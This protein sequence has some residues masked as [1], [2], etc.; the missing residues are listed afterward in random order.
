[1]R[2]ERTP[3]FLGLSAAIALA[4]LGQD[5]PAAALETVATCGQVVA[6]A[7]ILG[8][9]LDC[10]SETG[11][12]VVLQRGA[13]LTLA[14]FTI[15]GNEGGVLCTGPSCKIF[16]PGTIRRTVADPNTESYGIWGQQ[17][18]RV[19]D[20]VIL[21]NWRRGFL[22]LGSGKLIDV[23]ISG[24]VIGAN[25]A[26]LRVLGS[27]FSG[28]EFAVYGAEGTKDSGLHYTF[29]SCRVR[30][31]TFTGND[32]DISCYRAPKVT[33]TTCTTSWHTTIP[34]TPFSGGDEWGVCG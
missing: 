31:S 5:V 20:G 19:Q 12:A 11:P 13:R 2:T 21:E 18:T 33:D 27:S 10:S 17:G 4:V 7:G 8:A 16:G 24:S 28:N 23:S 1:M 14:G 32:I 26:P 15:T 6:Q 29:W 30:E 22:S 9:D 3:R 34:E 25:G